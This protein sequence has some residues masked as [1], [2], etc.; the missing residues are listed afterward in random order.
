MN[1]AYNGVNL[2]SAIADVMLD[3]RYNCMRCQRLRSANK[4][5]H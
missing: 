3:K 2:A 5:D 4:A 1:R